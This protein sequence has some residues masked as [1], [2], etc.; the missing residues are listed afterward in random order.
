MKSRT[1]R[2]FQ[3]NA[4]K[5]AQA[6]SLTHTYAI[7]GL[8]ESIL[9]CAGPWDTAL[10][11]DW[12]HVPSIG[13]FCSEAQVLPISANRWRKEINLISFQQIFDS[14]VKT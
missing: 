3:I 11:H 5:C 10:V 6:Y 14:L 4:L 7:S 9:L 2:C 12:R 13:K 8:R 1:S